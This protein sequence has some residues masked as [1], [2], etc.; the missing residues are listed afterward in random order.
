MAGSQD[1]AENIQNELAS[2]YTFRMQGS[3]Q[4]TQRRACQRHGNYPE[5]AYIGQSETT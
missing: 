4:K 5:N 3:T 1:G 2:H